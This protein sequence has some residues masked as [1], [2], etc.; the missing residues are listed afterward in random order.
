MFD[1]RDED[2]S[3]EISSHEL[4]KVL[5]GLGYE[6]TFKMV[7]KMLSMYDEDGIGSIGKGEFLNLTNSYRKLEKDR[8]RENAGFKD[9]EVEEYHAGFVRYDR[10]KS[11]ELSIQEL[12]VFLRDMNLYPRNKEQQEKL[13]VMMREADRDESGQLTFSEM[14]HLMRRFHDEVEV[15]QYAAQRKAQE[16]AGFSDEEVIDFWEIF[17]RFRMEDDDSEGEEFTIFALRSLL[18]SLGVTLNSKQMLELRGTFRDYAKPSS[19]QAQDNSTQFKLQ[20]PFPE[21]LMMMGHLIKN[22][23]ADLGTKSKMTAEKQ[24]KDREKM[25]LLMKQVQDQKQVSEGRRA[26]Q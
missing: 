3:G 22:D 11:G 21:F 8:I 24:A 16:N 15:E 12:L 18:R 9:D 26:T 19:V 25:D 2:G 1:E 20:L 5:A 13:D 17:A 14:L 10:D 4:G 6:P 23:F 7:A